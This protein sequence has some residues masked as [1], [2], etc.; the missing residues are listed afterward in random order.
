VQVILGVLMP[1]TGILKAHDGNTAWD[2]YRQSNPAPAIV[3]L[4]MMIPKRSGLLVLEK[5]RRT[6]ILANLP[7]V[8]MMTANAGSRHQ[9]FAES[10]GVFRYL[11][12]PFDMQML[13]QAIKDAKGIIC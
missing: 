8:I 9:A 6:S 12:K 4:D 11:R 7:R 10:L 2:V 5:I 3:I 1:K 13:L